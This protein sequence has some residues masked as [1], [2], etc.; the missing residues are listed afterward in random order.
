MV[1][2]AVLLLPAELIHAQTA[3]PQTP[4]ANTVTPEFK[5]SG[6]VWGYAFGDYYLKTHADSLNRG[7]T[8]Y[9]GKLYPKDF[10][11]FDFR[12]IYLGYSY[13]I[14]EDFSTELILAHE[15]DV[16][17]GSGDRMVYV[18]AANLRWK[19]II[20]NNDLVIGQT[21]TPIFAMVSEKVWGYRSIEKTVADMR[22]FGSSTDMG[23][24]WQ[25]KL[26][27]KGNYGYNFMIGNGT[28]QK[29]EN[30]RYKKFYGEVYAKLMDQ[31]I[32][33]DFTSDHEV[34]S[35][36]QSKTTV[37]G[38]VAY[39]TNPL[40][41]GIEV[42]NQLQKNYKADSVN[43]SQVNANVVPLAFSVFV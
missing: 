39:Q 43:G 17:N 16:V 40:T 2:L 6:R 7:K 12:R 28:A 42:V 20:H 27:D 21:A 35:P 8:Q 19:N 23:V 38:F 22:G 37:K 30:N 34:S 4:N 31:R 26:D 9:A 5:P 36:T 13:N 10:N 18:K 3:T 24:A 14:S 33:L 15:G 29:L 25:G 41:V 32:I 11:A 1:A